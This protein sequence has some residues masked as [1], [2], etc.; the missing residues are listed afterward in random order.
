M[1]SVRIN[2][3]I[4]QQNTILPSS[5]VGTVFQCLNLASLPEY[6]PHFPMSDLMLME[7]KFDQLFFNKLLYTFVWKSGLNV[8]NSKYTTQLLI[9]EQTDDGLTISKI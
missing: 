1:L 7:F 6:I 5:I 2:D 4:P 8:E 9:S 3:Q